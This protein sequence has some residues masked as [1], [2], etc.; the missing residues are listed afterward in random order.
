MTYASTLSKKHSCSRRAP[1][2]FSDPVTGSTSRR[3]PLSMSMN[4][5]ELRCNTQMWAFGCFRGME[6]P[7][8]RCSGVSLTSPETRRSL[9]K[10]LFVYFSPPMPFSAIQYSFQM[11]AFDVTRLSLHVV[12][13]EWAA[14]IHPAGSSTSLN[15]VRVPILLCQ[16][17]RM[18]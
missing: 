4:A 14:Q 10:S 6:V 11:F 3:L 17:E 2:F 13:L 1:R 7:H 16:H 15:S 9:V 8:L 12:M 5:S 18:Q